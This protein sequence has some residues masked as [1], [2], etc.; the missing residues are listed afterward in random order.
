MMYIHYCRHCTR[1]HILN[2]HKVF[3]PACETKLTEL[4]M[5]Y[6]TYVDLNISERQALLNTL[7]TNEQ[8]IKNL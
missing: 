7:K 2:G 3:C 4:K 6:L 5:S 1:L 8:N